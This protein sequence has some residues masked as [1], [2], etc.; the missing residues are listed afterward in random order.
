VL[1]CRASVDGATDEQLSRHLSTRTYVQAGDLNSSYQTKQTFSCGSH[2]QY[3]PVPVSCGIYAIL[4][5][6]GQ[7]KT[8]PFVL[9][10]HAYAFYA[11]LRSCISVLYSWLRADG[12]FTCEYV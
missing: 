2:G 5:V 4:L 3:I 8:S 7:L 12:D 6:A 1:V 9:V 10:L 11:W